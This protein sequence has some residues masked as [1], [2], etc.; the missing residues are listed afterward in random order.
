MAVFEKFCSEILEVYILHDFDNWFTSGLLWHHGTQ[1]NQNKAKNV[2]KANI[3]AGW[4]DF[5][6]FIVFSCFLHHLMLVY[7]GFDYF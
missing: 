6:V 1:K 5:G 4:V 7:T 3:K 2:I